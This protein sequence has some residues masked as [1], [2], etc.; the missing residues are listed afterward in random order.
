ML[1]GRN[2]DAGVLLVVRHHAIG[3]EIDPAGVGIAHDD[4]AVGADVAAAVLL[5]DHRHRKF[6]Q[7]DGLVAVDVFQHRPV[8]DGHR[9]DQPEV[10]L[11]AVAIGLHQLG[12]LVAVGKAERIGEPAAGIVQAGDDAHAAADSP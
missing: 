6:E 7:V 9:R 2:P 4:D 10:V 5:V 12:R 1:A 8:L 3:A 11:H